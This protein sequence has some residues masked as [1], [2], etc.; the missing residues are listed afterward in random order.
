MQLVYEILK[1][2]NECEN[3]NVLPELWVID[4]QLKGVELAEYW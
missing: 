4:V 1:P 2:S 3:Y